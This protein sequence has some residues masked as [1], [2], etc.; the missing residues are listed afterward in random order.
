MSSTAEVPRPSLAAKIDRLFRTVRGPDGRELT[1]DYV[2]EQIAQRGATTISANYLYMLRRGI[3]D[4]P[5][6]KHVEAL[7]IF[8]GV[9]PAHFFDEVETPADD[10]RR[11]F[12]RP[13]VRKVAALA[14]KLPQEVLGEVTRLLESADRL[15]AGG[16]RPDG[17]PAD[18]RAGA[19]RRPAEVNGTAATANPGRDRTALELSYAQ[20][21]L[22]HGDARQAR[23]R[24][25]ALLRHPDADEDE[26]RVRLAQVCDRDG[27][28]DAAIQTLG[29]VHGRCLDGLSRLNICAVSLMLAG[30][31][32]KAGDLNAAVAAAESGMRAAERA[33]LQGT[34]EYLRLGASVMSAHME[35]GNYAWVGALADRI[36][37]SLDDV[38]P[39]KGQA[40][41]LWNASIAAEA[42]GDLA[43][44]LDLAQRAL[45]SV[46][47]TESHRDLPRLR[48]QVAWLLLRSDPGTA[49]EAGRLLDLALPGLQSGG[50]RED[51]A[52]WNALRAAVHLRTGRPDA[53]EQHVRQALRLVPPRRVRLTARAHVIL[54]DVLRARGQQASALASYDAAR[55]VLADD[56][57]SRMAAPVWR[58]LAERLRELGQDAALDAYARSLD[59]AG[60]RVSAP[61][62]DGVGGAV[63]V[64]LTGEVTG[65][66]S[67][68]V[69]ITTAPRQR[70]SAARV[71]N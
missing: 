62:A 53:A 66:A 5:T 14:A 54:G 2:A 27:D 20:L 23:T 67:S 31:L 25:E 9:S 36:M 24:L 60:V 71:R 8:F 56:D 16:A 47:D 22:E 35:L 57:P 68:E 69:A 43:D 40:A 26:V 1:Y 49:T 18:S 17:E 15:H 42:R 21:A 51:L 58:D 29:Q 65:L 6:K 32:M 12:E 39:P 28:L 48:M 55:R 7:A 70:S 19:A 50:Q 45:R 64:D 63:T 59:A 61:P 30:Y 11:L 46:Q 44:A 41:I 4:N 33:G 38:N 10:D 37:T 13:D 34:A 52:E 3:R